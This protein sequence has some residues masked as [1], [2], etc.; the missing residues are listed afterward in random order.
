MRIERNLLVG[1][2]VVSE[3]G[4]ESSNA[5]QPEITHMFGIPPKC[6]LKHFQIVFAQTGCMK[7]KI[8]LREVQLGPAQE[9]RVT[10]MNNLRHATGS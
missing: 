5:I 2:A 1:S 8:R 6:D 10:D 9:Q 4:Y 3:A 7:E